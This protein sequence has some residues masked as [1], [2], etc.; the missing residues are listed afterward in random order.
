M[1]NTIDYISIH[2]LIK[3]NEIIIPEFQRIINN[4]KIKEIIDYQLIIS[5]FQQR[6]SKNSLSTDSLKE[7][8]GRSSIVLFSNIR[9]Q[10]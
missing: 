9:I 6:E 2:D 1:N 10:L 8:S 3:N 7:P 4:N 5:T